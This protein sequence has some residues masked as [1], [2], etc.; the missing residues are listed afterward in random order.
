MTDVT[1]SQRL[2]LLTRPDNRYI[3]DAVNGMMHR[4]GVISQIPYVKEWGIANL[5]MWKKLKDVI[6]FR[7][8]TKEIAVSRINMKQEGLHDA[9]QNLL[10]AKDPETDEGLSLPEILVE[11]AVLVVAGR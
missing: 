6:R 7:D 1:F 8:A 10:N 9:F 5:I 11:S 3:V 2:Q 4:V